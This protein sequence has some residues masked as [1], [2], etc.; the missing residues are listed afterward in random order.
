MLYIPE[1]FIWNLLYIMIVCQV[2]RGGGENEDKEV[3][4]ST[5]RKELNICL[6]G[7]RSGGLNPRSAGHQVGGS[8]C[9]TNPLPLHRHN[10]DI[11]QTVQQAGRGA[12]K[13]PEQSGEGVMVP[14]QQKAS[15]RAVTGI[16]ATGASEAGE[17]PSKP[18]G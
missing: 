18:R 11:R 8:G 3:R 14:C 16:Q 2:D 6:L 4:R 17:K 15:G 13:Y 5:G 7:R 12:T 10:Y 9:N 1:I